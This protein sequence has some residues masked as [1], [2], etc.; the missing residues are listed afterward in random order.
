[1]DGAITKEPWRPTRPWSLVT[2]FPW[3]QEQQDRIACPGVP[4]EKEHLRYLHFDEGDDVARHYY[5]SILEP[6][7]CWIENG[8]AGLTS[9]VC[10]LSLWSCPSPQRSSSLYKGQL[11]PR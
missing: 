2:F 10:E 4:S 7:R 9:R 1:M 6:G 5:E 8:I 3:S 11:F